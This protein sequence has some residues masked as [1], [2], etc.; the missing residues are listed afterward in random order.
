MAHS[1]VAEGARIV[2]ADTDSDGIGALIASLGHNYVDGIVCDFRDDAR[3]ADAVALAVRR[4]GR[5][6][7]AFNA[8]YDS[9]V[10]AAVMEKSMSACLHHEAE[11]LIAQGR[12]G[13]II[14][15]YGESL[16]AEAEAPAALV[17]S[18]GVD[19]HI[20]AAAA[21]FRPRHIRINAVSC[22][23]VAEALTAARVAVYLASDAAA[24]ITG[25]VFDA[26]NDAA[27]RQYPELASYLA[28]IRD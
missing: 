16:V 19:A 2:V 23:T 22:Q 28:E 1:A 10:G 5:L 21:V 6:D 17:V 8:T 15:F 4:F 24:E 14:N 25:Q 27:I 12:G 7:A 11:Q 26:G 3:V 13:S 9:G 18:P 20:G